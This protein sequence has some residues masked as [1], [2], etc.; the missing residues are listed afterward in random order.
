M[1]SPPRSP[2]APARLDPALAERQIRRS[3]RGFVYGLIGLVP[4]AGLGTAIL[5]RRLFRQTRQELGAH[6]PATVLDACGGVL[7]LAVLMHRW[8]GSGM[9]ILVFLE[10]SLGLSALWYA[11]EYRRRPQ[12]DSNPASSYL[13]LGAAL[14]HW[15]V[16]FSL[17]VCGYLFL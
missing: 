13:F 6:R 17:V 12:P 3:L 11:S 9:V 7:T 5:A 2:S 16:Y 8:P 10:A 4:L 14:G 15:G 1:T